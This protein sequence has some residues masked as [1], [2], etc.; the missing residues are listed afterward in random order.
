MK[1]DLAEIKKQAKYVGLQVLSE[2]WEAILK[3]GT[4][5]HLSFSGLLTGIVEKEYNNKVDKEKQ[6]RI[7]RARIPEKLVL[8]TFPFS[9]QP[10][11]DRKIEFGLYDSLS[12]MKEKQDLIFIGPTGCGKTG[13]ATGFLMRAID[14]G[15][16]GLFTD[17]SSL[18]T[19]LHQARGDRSEQRLMK[20]LTSYDILLIDELG[21]KSCDKEQASLFFDLIRQ[22]HSRCSTV[23]TT[24][25]GF[26]EW[27]LFLQNNHMTAAMLDRITVNCAVF[28]MKDCI[29]IRAKKVIYTVKKKP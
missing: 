19:R 18:I 28:N 29:S 22:R 11:L 8:E 7:Q 24:Q 10:R 15:Y 6:A 27:G 1:T 5:K 14:S 16:R 13:L 2:N 23:I 9:K 21:Y 4:R 17:F 20:K 25:L 12:F 26:D 3:E